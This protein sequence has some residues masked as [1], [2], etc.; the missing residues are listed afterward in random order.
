MGC[1]TVIWSQ[2]LEPAA[3][4]GI[5]CAGLHQGQRHPG[6]ITSARSGTTPAASSSSRTIILNPY[7]GLVIASSCDNDKLQLT[8]LLL[9]QCSENFCWFSLQSQI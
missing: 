1:L 8:Y 9:V 4:A 6:S 7:Y 2:G 3:S 5:I